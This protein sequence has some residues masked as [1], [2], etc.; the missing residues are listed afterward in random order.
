[1]GK[2]DG[3]LAR[4]VALVEYAETHGLD[5]AAI[6]LC[7][8]AEVIAPTLQESQAHANN[9]LDLAAC[10]KRLRNAATREAHPA[11]TRVGG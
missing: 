3:F 10:R 7:A 8:A 11:E 1:M 4:L 6:A 9:V 2:H 5:V